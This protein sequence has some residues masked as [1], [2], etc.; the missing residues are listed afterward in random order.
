MWSLGY[1]DPHRQSCKCISSPGSIGRG[2]THRPERWFQI[3]LPSGSPDSR[4]RDRA[5]GEGRIGVDVGNRR[6][7]LCRVPRPRLA[8]V[9]C[10]AERPRAGVHRSEHLVIITIE[11]QFEKCRHPRERE[12]AA[13]DRVTVCV[14]SQAAD[15]FV[16]SSTVLLEVA[17]AAALSRRGITAVT[18]DLG[19]AMLLNQ[20]T[21]FRTTVTGE[22]WRALALFGEPRADL[23]AGTLIHVAPRTVHWSANRVRE[24]IR[25]EIARRKHTV[26]AAFGRC[27]LL[28]GSRRLWARRSCFSVATLANSDPRSV[29]ASAVSLRVAKLEA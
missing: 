9:S 3:G 1:S 26:L 13:A 11:S 25:F 18:C 29:N 21:T 7:L 20:G 24:D 6:Q 4:A 2:L 17:S 22:A 16:D 14:A 12:K 19:I 15:A 23:L 5:M 28:I 27:V 10:S 8:S